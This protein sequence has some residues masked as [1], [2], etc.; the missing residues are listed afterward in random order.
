MYIYDIYKHL[1]KK[2]WLKIIIQIYDTP[3]KYNSKIDDPFFKSYI[4]GRGIKYEKFA[5]EQNKIKNIAE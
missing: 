1:N 4:E 5:K 3:G 2:I